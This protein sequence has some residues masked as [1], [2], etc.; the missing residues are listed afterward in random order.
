MKQDSFHYSLLI[1]VK[2]E[3]KKIRH[4]M[5]EISNE[6]LIKKLCL[7]QQLWLWCV[8]NLTT[9]QRQNAPL[10]KPQI[11]T[12]V[13]SRS[14]WCWTLQDCLWMFGLPCVHYKRKRFQVAD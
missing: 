2:K 11:E 4:E 14:S 7:S 13:P 1:R 10:S 3:K 12:A 9:G 8:L 5:H 6:L